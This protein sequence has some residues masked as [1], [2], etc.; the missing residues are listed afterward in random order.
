[1][2]PLVKQQA[3][4]YLHDSYQDNKVILNLYNVRKHI[5]PDG[6]GFFITASSVAQAESIH[7]LNQTSDLALW[8]L[9]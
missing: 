2:E 3:S 4:Y 7:L 6:T 1:M 5:H 9:I 8:D